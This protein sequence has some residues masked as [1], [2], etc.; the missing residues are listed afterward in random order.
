MTAF[1]DDDK[2]FGEDAADQKPAA[3]NK[4]RSNRPYVRLF[5]DLCNSPAWRAL[6]DKAHRLLRRLELE[7]MKHGGAENGNLKCTYEDFAKWGLRRSSVAL[8]IR[9]CV[10]LGFLAITYHGRRTI[11]DVRL[12]S[13]Y[14]LTYIEGRNNSPPL[15]DE[16]RQIEDDKTAAELLAKA[17][18][19]RKKRKAGRTS[20]P[21]PGTPAV[22]SRA[23]RR[24]TTA[25]KTGQKPDAPAGH[26][27]IYPSQGDTY[28]LAASSPP[29]ALR[30]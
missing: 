19:C 20:G 13:K 27:Y 9:Q 2:P 18:Q 11:A 21:E 6:P 28:P 24:V 23:H 12:P 15:T 22:R 16:W 1:D 14:R 3:G 4:P 7:H 17:E 26:L 10:A 29:S 8:C 5:I 25:N 30:R